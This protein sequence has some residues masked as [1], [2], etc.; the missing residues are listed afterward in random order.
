MVKA[1]GKVDKGGRLTYAHPHAG[2]VWVERFGPV[3]GSVPAQAQE[4]KAREGT[5]ETK[6]GENLVPLGLAYKMPTKDGS[7]GIANHH[8]H[9]STACSRDRLASSHLEVNGDSIEQL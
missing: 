7:G 9:N 8:R 3:G 2:K 5:A 4:T 6:H 1:G